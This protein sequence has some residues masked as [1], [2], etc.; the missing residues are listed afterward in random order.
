V[1][2]LA[3]M[4]E[5]VVERVSRQFGKNSSRRSFLAKS[6]VVGSALAVNPLQ[7]VLK[8]GSAYAAIGCGP[9]ADCASGWTVFCCSVNAGRNT[10]P[11][12][13]IPAGWWKTDNSPFCHGGARF[14]VDCN[15]TCGGCGC[16]SSGICAPGCY[17][18]GCRCNTGSCDQRRHCCNEFRYGQC[19]QE[20]GC[21]GPVVCRVATCAPPWQFDASC[22]TASATDNATVLHAA[23][24]LEPKPKVEEPEMWTITAE[25]P[26][27]PAGTP[28]ANRSHIEIA[29]PPG[30]KTATLRLYST[31]P[32]DQGPAVWGAIY[33]KGSSQGLWASGHTWELW[34]PGQTPIDAVINPKAF[35]IQ[36]INNGAQFNAAGTPVTITVSG[37]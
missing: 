5:R 20:I 30:F 16:G 14:I 3:T 31:W 36:L 34:L 18:C 13:S 22:T 1:S 19:H 11:A 9:A 33:Y 7:Y 12:G 35:A 4:S 15:A 8:P 29:L 28:R 2:G 21:V 32:H 10:C 23:P 25:L 17:N 6:A 27:T 37:T 24:C 26:G